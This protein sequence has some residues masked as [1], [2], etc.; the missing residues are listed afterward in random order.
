MMVMV[1]GPSGLSQAV[2]NKLAG[3][4]AKNMLVKT[5]A[6]YVCIYF[7]LIIS[8]V[9]NYKHSGKYNLAK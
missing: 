1:V 8:S 2:M 6:V 3:D 7:C 4:K 5:T 9:F